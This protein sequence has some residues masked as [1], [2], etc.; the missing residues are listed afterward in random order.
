M[1]GGDEEGRSS[2]R[3]GTRSVREDG[4]SIVG[5]KFYGEAVVME[6]AVQKTSR[7]GF[8]TQ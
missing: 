6:A 4:N 5:S 7:R 3:I 2:L 8:T 1:Q